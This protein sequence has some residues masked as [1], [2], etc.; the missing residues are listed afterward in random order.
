[1]DQPFP[2]TSLIATID[3]TLRDAGWQALQTDALNPGSPSSQVVG[4]D[5]YVD[6]RQTP[7]RTIHA[8][9]A[10]WRSASGDL[11]TYFFRYESPVTA[12][13]FA[14]ASPSTRTV[15]VVAVHN[16]AAAAAA[17]IESSHRMLTAAGQ[18]VSSGLSREDADVLRSIAEGFPLRPSLVNRSR[19]VCRGATEDACVRSQTI[20]WVKPLPGLIAAFGDRNQTSEDLPTVAGVPSVGSDL[21]ARPSNGPNSGAA[22]AWG[23]VYLWCSLPGYSLGEAVVECATR[24]GAAAQV[25]E[26]VY[27]FERRGSWHLKQSTDVPKR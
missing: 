25:Q 5:S 8:W 17:L 22:N 12:D 16:P 14:A 9:G 3:A 20:E 4:W 21:W 26:I 7:K 23:G 19:P 6:G 11:A 1:V 18:A 13:G 27:V 10:S 15:K 2:A 24:A